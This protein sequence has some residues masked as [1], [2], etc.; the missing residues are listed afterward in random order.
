MTVGGRLFLPQALE[1]RTSAKGGSYFP[2]PTATDPNRA[3]HFKPGT[4]EKVYSLEGMAKTGLWPTPNARDWKDSSAKQGNRK[5]PNLGSAVHMWA[6]P[7]AREFYETRESA[8]RRR[9]RDTGMSLATQAGGTLN[10]QWVE[11]LMGYTIGWTE[12]N[13]LGI[14]LFRPKSGKRSK[15][16]LDLTA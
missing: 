12:L 1:P 4:K 7:R 15:R 2:T 11:W 8:I 5:S 14:Q 13:A 9:G 10:P 16:S 3:Y 6:T